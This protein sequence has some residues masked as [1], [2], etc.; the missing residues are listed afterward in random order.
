MKEPGQQAW[1]FRDKV[2]APDFD[3]IL[4]EASATQNLKCSGSFTK[5]VK[6]WMISSF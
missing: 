1:T 3:E 6:I 5:S 2:L 4:P